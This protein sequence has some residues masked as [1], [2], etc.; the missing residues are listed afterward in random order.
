MAVGFSEEFFEERFRRKDNL[1]LLEQQIE[2]YDRQK[3][4]RPFDKEFVLQNLSFSPRLPERATALLKHLIPSILEFSATLDLRLRD[5]NHQVRFVTVSEFE[6]ETGLGLQGKVPLP[7]SRLAFNET[8]RV[9]TATVILPDAI[10]TSEEVINTTRTLFS[11]LI[12]EIYLNESVLPMEFYQQG[13]TQEEARVSA[14]MP[15]KLDIL[16]TQDVPSEGWKQECATFAKQYRMSLKKQGSQV[17][18]QL[19]QQWLQQWEKQELKPAQ[20][21]VIERAFEDF[22]EAFRQDSQRVLLRAVTELRKL[23][24]QL[25]FVLPHELKGYRRFETEDPA[26]YLRSVSNKLEEIVALIGFVEEIAQKLENDEQDWERKELLPQI[27]ARLQQLRQERKALVFLLPEANLTTELKKE[28]QQFSLRLMKLLSHERPVSE[29]KA[30]HRELQE[31]YANS[32]YLKLW[33]ALLGLHRW[34]ALPLQ[35]ATV[36]PLE[37]K[38]VQRLQQLRR[39][40][41]FRLKSMQQAQSTA[42][43]LTECAEQFL[44]DHKHQRFPLSEFRKAWSYFISSILIT[45]Y[46]GE[47][48]A[49]QG[50]KQRFNAEKYMNSIHEFVQRQAQ[51]GV[52]YYHLVWLFL[53]LY[54]RKQSDGNALPFLLYMIHYPQASLRFVFH[55][56]LAPAPEGRDYATE[57]LPKRQQ[58]LDEYCETLLK[59]YE[60]RLENAILPAEGGQPFT[61]ALR[62]SR[63]G[64]E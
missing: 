64:E 56:V 54:E 42:G 50:A 60:N 51:R 55:Q 8:S 23:D 22:I 13:G 35:D 45:R 41:Q 46:Y 1:N 47:H 29:W 11:K 33:E 10:R 32:I 63:Q 15:E 4:E 31:M 27:T 37:D 21:A 48:A 58:R 30:E 39:N 43:V 62:L 40:F 9:Y 7:A 25:H 16:R 17:R 53:K 59:V 34:I 2:E 44:T 61:N 14:G 20:Q 28:Q 6:A 24:K 18:E 5:P 36:D 26:H 12:G 49:K 19:T 3:A 57:E 52:S 38:R